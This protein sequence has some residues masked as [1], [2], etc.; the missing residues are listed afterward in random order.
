MTRVKICG[1][2]N[3]DDA[4]LAADCGAD[5]IG[6]VFADSPR[7]IDFGEAAEIAGAVPAFVARVGVFVNA[8]LKLVTD[9]LATFLDCVQLHGEESVFECEAVAF[10]RGR[11]RIIKVFRV[12]DKSDLNILDRYKGVTGMFHLDTRVPGKKGGTGR[13][14]DWNVAVEAKRW[15]KPVVLSGGLTPDNVGEAVGQVKPYAV[16]VSSGVES[17]PGVKDPKKVREFV[18][19]AKGAATG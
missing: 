17:E 16:D 6:F 4:L 5:A 9:C 7:R 11:S 14:F 2:T 15:G 13:T 10:C 18:K 8:P 1:I 3:V 19:R 12:H